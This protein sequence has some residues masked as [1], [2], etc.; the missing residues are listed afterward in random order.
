MSKIGQNSMKIWPFFAKFI[1]NLFVLL[2]YAFANSPQNQNRSENLSY[3]PE[4]LRYPMAP[5][6]HVITFNVDFPFA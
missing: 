3:F 2:K 1:I 6:F 4:I 5:I